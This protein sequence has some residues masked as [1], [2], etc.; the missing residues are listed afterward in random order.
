MK[1]DWALAGLILA[2]VCVGILLVAVVLTWLVDRAID[3]I[4]RRFRH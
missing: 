4:H 3:L 2:A 1:T